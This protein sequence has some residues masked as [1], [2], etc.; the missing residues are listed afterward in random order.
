M[1]IEEQA[2]LQLELRQTAEE[3][4]ATKE[5]LDEARKEQQQ[6]PIRLGTPAMSNVG[7]GALTIT[8]LTVRDQGADDTPSVRVQAFESVSKGILDALVDCDVLPS[9]K[10]A[11]LIDEA[12]TAEQPS[13]MLSSKS[14]NMVAAALKP[15]KDG[16]YE[17]L[18]SVA[19]VEIKRRRPPRD[20]P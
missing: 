5:A 8:D 10:A 14:Q 11:E 6:A 15:F 13:V 9:R 17:W 7:E 12:A 20:I 16:H 18:K 19:K 2:T 4:K 3:L 1:D